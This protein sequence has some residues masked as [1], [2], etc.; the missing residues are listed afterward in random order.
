MDFFWDNRE[1]QIKLF[2][3]NRD[4][5]DIFLRPSFFPCKIDLVF[6]FFN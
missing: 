6:F 1:I 3:D 2:G 4:V 5:G